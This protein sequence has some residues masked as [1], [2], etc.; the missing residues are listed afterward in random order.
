MEIKRVDLIKNIS[1]NTHVLIRNIKSLLF[2]SA[3]ILFGLYH[4]HAAVIT[5][6]ESVTVNLGSGSNVSYLIFN[7]ST[8]S[9]DPI[10]YAWHY[11]GLVNPLTGTNWSGEDLFQGVLSASKGTGYAL[12]VSTGASGLFTDFTI[13]GTKSA[14][15]DPL[16]SP[17]WTYWIS[18]GSEFVEYGDNGSFSFDVPSG[19]WIVSPSY[20]A[21]RRISN[22]SYDGWTISPFSYT[23][24]SSDTSFYNDVDGKSQPV[25]FGTYS[26]LDPQIIP[27]PGTGLLC[28][29]SS[30]ALLVFTRWTQRRKS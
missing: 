11:D 9:S 27:E 2:L 18:G 1:S 16:D 14:S 22:G 28:L 8:L 30:A 4:V 19:Q 6:Q 15:V 25:T 12:S 17:V 21:T 29:I 13:G 20:T 23:G 5:G 26:G 24:A 10:R 7:E 3:S